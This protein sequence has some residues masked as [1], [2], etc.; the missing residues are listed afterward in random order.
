MAGSRPMVKRIA[1]IAES[2]WTGLGTA[3]VAER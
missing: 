2:G 1:Q 3:A